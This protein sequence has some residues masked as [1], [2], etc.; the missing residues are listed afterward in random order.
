MSL[1]VIAKNLWTDG[2]SPETYAGPGEKYQAAIMEQYKLYVEMADRVTSRRN[3]ANAFF[4]TL[5]TAIFSAVGAFW[6]RHPTVTPGWWAAIPLVLVLA[7]C[8]AWFRVVRSYRQLNT[9]K[10]AVVAAFEERLPAGPY[11]RAE[12]RALG[13][14]RDR[15]KYFQITLLEQWIPILFATTYAVGFTVI[16]L[17]P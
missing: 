13:E 6:Q 11:W 10:W 8:T 5:N 4:L 1:E 7:Q 9:A 17:F 15:Q 12:W 16:F 14:G 2:V 3:A